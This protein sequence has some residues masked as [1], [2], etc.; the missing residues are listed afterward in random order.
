MYVNIPVLW[1][2]I[3]PRNLS[4]VEPLVPWEFVCF[5]WVGVFCLHGAKWLFGFHMGDFATQLE[6]GI[7]IMINRE[8]SISY[9]PKV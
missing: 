9:F 5:R 3:D 2:I 4:R 6:D 7:M 8:S 1:N